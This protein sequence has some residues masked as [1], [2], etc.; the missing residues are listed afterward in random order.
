MCNCGEIFDN[1]LERVA[2]GATCP[3]MVPKS[4]V[5]EVI[6]KSV[7]D[8]LKADALRLVEAIDFCASYGPASNVAQAAR[9]EWRKKY[10]DPK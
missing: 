4:R 1:S 10:G 6:E 2:H 5:I 3:L 7:Y 8:E 9:E